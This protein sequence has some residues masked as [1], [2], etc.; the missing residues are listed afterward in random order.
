MRPMR[1]YGGGGRA[2]FDFRR[3]MAVKLAIALVAV[4]VI[5]WVTPLGAYLVLTPSAVLS[6]LMVW[7]PLTYVFIEND[8]LGVIFGALIVWQM[9][10]ALEASWGTK[11]M[12]SFAV[13][14]TAIAGALTVL[15]ALVLPSLR[16]HSYFGGWAMSGALWVAYGLS[17]GRG[18]TNFWGMPVSGNVFAGIGAAFVLL[19]AAR[20]GPASV[21]PQLLALV[22]TFL[23]VRGFSPRVLWL[24]LQGA[25]LQRRLKSRSKHLRVVDRDRNMPRDSDRFLH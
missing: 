24:R 25:M 18:Q 14:V 8:P 9:G 12:V 13:G 19:S 6:A 4:S 23:Y 1:S 17:F 3:T 11:R 20:F 22:L 10:S 16:G 5:A 21:A 7:Q 2:G 15:L